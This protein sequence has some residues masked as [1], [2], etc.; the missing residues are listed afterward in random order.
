[1]E[2]MD[3][4]TS[5]PSFVLPSRP[6]SGRTAG[7]PNNEDRVS[8]RVSLCHH[9]HESLPPPSRIQTVLG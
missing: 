3:D 4:Q 5:F 6:D 7:V 8:E 1:M 9:Y 2:V